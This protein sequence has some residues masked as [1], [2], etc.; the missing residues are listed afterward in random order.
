M[1]AGGGVGGMEREGDTWMPAWNIRRRTR[2]EE[3]SW[4]HVAEEGHVVGS[5]VQRQQMETRF[6]VSASDGRFGG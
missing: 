6:G 1:Y 5:V 3:Y 4:S 2:K